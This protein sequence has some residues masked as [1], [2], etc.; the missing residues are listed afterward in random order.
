MGI[1]MGENNKIKNSTIAERINNEIPK[2]NFIERHSLIV[3]II[4][5]FVVGFVLMFSFW[6]EIILWMEGLI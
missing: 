1:F 6:D 2:K 3:S 5:S 4:T